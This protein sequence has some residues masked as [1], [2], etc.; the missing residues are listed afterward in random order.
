MNIL[1]GSFPAEQSWASGKEARLNP[2]R[3]ADLTVGSLDEVLFPL[4]DDGDV[5]CTR[6]ARSERLREYH[7]MLGFRHDERACT[8]DR[9]DR[10]DTY[11]LL[12]D[13]V[14]AEWLKGA[15][16]V[17]G[18]LVPWAVTR[19]SAPL[20]ERYGV[21][22]HVPVDVVARVNS[23]IWST[24]LRRRIDPG[25]PSIVTSSAAELLHFGTDYLRRYGPIVIKEPHGVSGG[26]TVGVESEHR[27]RQI[28]DSLAVQE[29][30]GCRVRMILEPFL[31]KLF[32]FS[33]Y[34]D[35]LPDGHIRQAGLQE[36]LV[37]GFGW[38]AAMPMTPEHEAAACTPRYFDT[39]E[40]ICRALH[41]EGYAGPVCIDSM[42]L[43]NGDIVPLVE[44]NA[45]LSLGRI[46]HRLNTAIAV[47]RRKSYFSMIRTS[48]ERET[49]GEF[50]DAL[51]AAGGLFGAG[52]E[53]GVIPLS[54]NTLGSGRAPG[55][56]YFSALFGDSLD[57]QRTIARLHDVLGRLGAQ[58][59]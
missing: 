54:S 53:A 5:L 12:D 20:L 16:A 48:L 41:E 21:V 58:I 10:R 7:A 14:H 15:M 47:H 2:F 8:E 35:L 27:L 44:V 49:F 26:G 42:V 31:N 37:T 11:A 17:G 33:I 39:I 51:A 13:E 34:I 6:F 38:S 59:F 57:L 23:K 32:D 25:D 4:C 30:S 29:R 55:R 24:E 50:L 45:R 36:A 28:V 46:N 18:R 22:D 3:A 1:V 52:S 19:D 43:A 9:S 56:L 40:N